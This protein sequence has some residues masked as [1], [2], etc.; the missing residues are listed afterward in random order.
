MSSSIHISIS[1]QSLNLV[2]QDGF[3]HSYSISSAA[4][5]IGFDEGSYCT[6]TG[7]FQVAEKHGCH[8][9]PFTMFVGRK[10]VGI[11]DMTEAST[12]DHVL[13]R[14]L[15]LDGKDSQNANT[16]ERYIYI[17]GTNQEDLIGIPV[18]CGCI[19]MRNDDIID[20][21]DRVEEGCC[22]VIDL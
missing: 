12:K 10:P 18:S 2:D 21:Y 9:A 17:H 7:N 16:K 15:W 20:L 14:I 6:P 1:K 3:V 11:H 8:A 13:T 22:V 4:N 5:G 19:R